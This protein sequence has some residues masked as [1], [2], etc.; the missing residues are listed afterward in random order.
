MIGSST[1]HMA[2]IFYSS[3]KNKISVE[4]KFEKLYLLNDPLSLGVIR[5]VAGLFEANY[6][7]SNN[8]SEGTS[9]YLADLLS[10]KEKHEINILIKAPVL[11]LPQGSNIF[12]ADLGQI[13]FLS[14]PKYEAPLH[15]EVTKTKMFYQSEFAYLNILDQE[16]AERGI[17]NQ[18]MNDMT[19]LFDKLDCG[20][21]FGADLE[22]KAPKISVD[23]KPI[24]FNLEG[25]IYRALILMADDLVEKAIDKRNKLEK[26][27]N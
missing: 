12:V 20:I 17:I 24:E 8:V 15:I 25:H 5:E 23:L 21:D 11:L 19:L 16:M 13:Q 22:T 2:D 14:G 3:F 4:G 1:D 6:D 27:K 18:S 7:I 9:D 10:G 26:L